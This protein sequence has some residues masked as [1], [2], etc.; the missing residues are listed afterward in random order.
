MKHIWS[1]DILAFTLHAIR[2]NIIL[3]WQNLAAYRRP[4]SSLYTFLIIT[5]LIRLSLY[6]YRG[7]FAFLRS[8]FWKYLGFWSKLAVV[9]YVFDLFSRASLNFNLALKFFNIN[10][11]LPI[12]FYL[13]RLQLSRCLIPTLL[14][15][16]IGIK[17][18]IIYFHRILWSTTPNRLVQQHGS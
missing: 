2:N 17:F 6:Y 8:H 18:E 12:L 10:F 14:V 11:D 13:W 15:T 4:A 5:T 1:C 16:H 9:Y 7:F 3:R